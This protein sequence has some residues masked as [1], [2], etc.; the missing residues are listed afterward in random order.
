MR[1]STMGT[2]GSCPCSLR[3][4][5]IRAPCPR[6]EHNPH[7]GDVWL[8]LL[9][10]P[11]P[12]ERLKGPRCGD[13]DAPSPASSP[14]IFPS[15]PPSQL[16]VVRRSRR[17]LRGLVDVVDG[18]GRREREAARPD[19]AHRQPDLEREAGAWTPSATALCSCSRARALSSLPPSAT[20][21]LAP[22]AR[23][24]ALRHARRRAAEG[25]RREQRR[26]R[27][28][29]AA[30]LIASRLPATRERRASRGR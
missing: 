26:E 12:E 30:L 9:Q 23:R 24:P 10:S 11:F 15:C 2:P 1:P 21:P 5:A 6:G 22:L 8:W 14:C 16:G 13:L 19:L 29:K 25:R 28:R 3:P 18:D 7:E 27:G 20:S 4:S 17:R